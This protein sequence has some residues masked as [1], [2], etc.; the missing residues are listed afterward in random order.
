MRRSNHQ[1]VLSAPSA[2]TLTPAA[3]PCN[4]SPALPLAAAEPAE[5]LDK[6]V[7]VVTGNSVESIVKDPT[8]DVLL[9][10]YAPWCGHCKVRVPCMNG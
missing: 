10:V 6:G 8:K 4:H 7:R 2:D 1:A 3:W 9:E 5:P